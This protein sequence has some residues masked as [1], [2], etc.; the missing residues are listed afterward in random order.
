MDFSREANNK[1]CLM[2]SLPMLVSL[3]E[4]AIK[5]KTLDKMYGDF[6][7]EALKMGLSSYTLNVL[8]VNA[9]KSIENNDGDCDDNSVIPFIYRTDVIKPKPEIQFVYKTQEEIVVKNKK[10]YGFIIA[11]IIVLLLNVGIIALFCQNTTNA[12]IST[13]YSLSSIVSKL[14]KVKAITQIGDAPI[15][16]FD[17]WTSTNKEHNSKSNKDYSFIVKRG[18]YKLSFDY[19]VSSESEYDKLNVYLFTH[20]DTINLLTI[21][22]VKSGTKT[23]I[24]DHSGYITVRFEY[25]KDGSY[26]KN[27]D[28]VKISNINVYKPYN[29]QI[30][31]IKEILNA[32]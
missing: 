7:E 9:K 5:E 1:D 14:D 30:N 19:D 18:G 25:N 22:G 23:Y 4:T 16:S 13:N 26:H 17:S 27:K 21:S 6:L 3:I 31:E 8:I 15:C 20:S 12:L 2:N 11:L 28:V 29:V 24:L 32:D 10:G